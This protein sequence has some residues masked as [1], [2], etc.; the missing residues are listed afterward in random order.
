MA[1]V[2]EE[3]ARTRADREARAKIPIAHVRVVDVDISF[4][5]MVWL[6]VK[7]SVAAIPAFIILL[8]IGVVITAILGVLLGGAAGLG[9]LLR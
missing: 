6:L 2:D 8:V 3:L 4:G 9:S 1:T 5:Q 7:L